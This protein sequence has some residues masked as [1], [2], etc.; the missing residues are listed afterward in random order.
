MATCERCG[1]PVE[2][3]NAAGWYRDHCWSCIE[4]IADAETP[5]RETC[6][7]PDC[8]VCAAP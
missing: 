1:E 8:R 4:D 6:S 5:H 2:V 7:D 3:K